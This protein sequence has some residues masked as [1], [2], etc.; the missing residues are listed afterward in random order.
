M[1]SAQMMEEVIADASV[2]ELVLEGV[3]DDSWLVLEDD[4]SVSK[5]AATPSDRGKAPTMPR[6]ALATKSFFQRIVSFGQS[7]PRDGQNPRPALIPGALPTRKRQSFRQKSLGIGVGL[8]AGLA[9]IGGYV[10]L[11]GG[12]ESTVT[13]SDEVAVQQLVEDIAVHPEPADPIAASLPSGP[14]KQNAANMASQGQGTANPLEECLFIGD[15]PEFPWRS[16]LERGLAHLKKNGICHFFGLDP[17]RISSAL[18]GIPSFGPTG[19]DLLPSAQV[20]EF[21]PSGKISR[22]APTL[23][24]VFV[25]NVAVEIRLNYGSRVAKGLQ[26]DVF[27]E[28]FGDAVQKGKD[29][30]GRQFVRYYDGDMVAEQFFRKDDYGRVFKEIRFT[31]KQA[32]SHLKTAY[33]RMRRAEAAFTA[34]MLAYNEHKLAEA[35]SGFKKAQQLVPG[36]G[37]AYIWEGRLHVGEERFEQA[38]DVARLAMERSGD[39][40]VLAEA[41]GLQ[42]VSALYEGNQELALQHFRTANEV[43]PARSEFKNSV[44][45]LESGEYRPDRV[46]KT[47]ARM[48]CSYDKKRRTGGLPDHA[49]SWTVK[50]L[51]ARGNF[52]DSDTYNRALKKSKRSRVFKR[53]YKRWV[54]WECR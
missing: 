19:Y 43:D 11:F 47:A 35:L 53:E 50:G 34:G 5:G 30:N 26:N 48:S 13:M 6:A 12:A 36:Y 46:A 45:E 23:V 40:R 1:A 18:I 27:A 37:A 38:V 33:E 52:P 21:Y 7:K 22:F 51:L 4:E 42:G 24:F 31:S 44:D 9:A 3:D 28:T 10:A 32:L 8:A 2:L 39:Q 17:A 49:K 15:L 29:G 25:G 16:F 41:W 54:T 14:E 20:M